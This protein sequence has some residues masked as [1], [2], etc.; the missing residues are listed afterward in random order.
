[1]TKTIGELI[2][3]LSILNIKIFYLVEKVQQDKHTR[4]DAKKLQ[5]LNKQ[6]SLFTN[7][8]NEYF[9]ERQEIKV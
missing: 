5:D 2:D 6:R 3:G 7:A 1:V 9:N 8:I 4:E